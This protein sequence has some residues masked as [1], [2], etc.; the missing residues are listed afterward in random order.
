MRLFTQVSR[1]ELEK[2]IVSMDQFRGYAILAMIFVNFVGGFDITPW[3]LKHHRTG[4]SYNDTIAPI[5]VFVVGMGMRLS[6]LKRSAR[7][8]ARLARHVAAKRYILLTIIG[9]VIYA[10]YLWDALTDIGIAGLLS[11]PFIDRGP[12]ARTATALIFLTLY[13]AIYSL[14]GY[15][16]WVLEHS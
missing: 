10:G 13:Q 6:W 7:D 3:L 16:D 8:G 9:F 2:R 12:A 15:G 5:F 4:M 14:T 1:T 11:L